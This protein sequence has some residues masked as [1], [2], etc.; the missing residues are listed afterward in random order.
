LT[1][2]VLLTL[3]LWSIAGTLSPALAQGDQAQDPIDGALEEPAEDLP[4]PE[5]VDVDPTA[6]DEEIAERLSTILRSTGWFTNPEVAVQE[7]VVF[8]DGETEREEYQQWATELARNTEDV[9][10]VVNRIRVVEPLTWDLTPAL[11]EVNA[12]WRR[13]VRLLPLVLFGLLVLVVAWLAS[14]YTRRLARQLLR[15]RIR[16]P[17]LRDVT[18]SVIGVPVFLLGLYIVLQALGLTR[19]ALTILGGTGLAGLV[20]G[21]AFQ[22]IMENFLA[23]ILISTRQPF[24]SGDRITVCGHT[25]IVQ[26]VT[27]RGTVLLALDGNYIQIPNSTIYKSTIVNYTANPRSR[28]DFSVGIGYEEEIKGV[29][30][31]ILDVLRQ[32]PV[33][34]PQPESLVLVDR[35][36]AATVNLTVFFWMDVNA[37]EPLKVRSSV[38]RLVK[39]ALDDS[40]VS[41]PDEAREVIFPKGVPIVR[42]EEVAEGGPEERLPLEP[43]LP[44]PRARA[45]VV[46]AAEPLTT[47]AE[48]DLRSEDEQLREQARQ[49]RSP[50]E[51]A[52]LLEKNGE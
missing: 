5:Q 15:E 6:A 24:R 48:G 2:L 45:P 39:R 46:E 23:S 35:L 16:S 40:G 29:Q 7:G 42:V 41:M 22:D 18:A 47:D 43:Q 19:L 50:E 14:H 37:H 38:I 20:V 12:L 30:T 11:E 27:T 10:A 33:V 9:V 26:Q 25:G 1:A 31:I 32:H 13:L 34:L 3:A 44:P 21:I 4:V 52:D 17:L 8:L 36:G 28:I 51:G 49:S